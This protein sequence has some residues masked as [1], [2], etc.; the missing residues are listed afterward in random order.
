MMP[1]R[2]LSTVIGVALAL[3][4][5]PLVQVIPAKADLTFDQ[6]MVELI[7]QD[8][9]ANGLRPVAADPTLSAQAEDAPYS[10]CG[11][12]VNGRAMDMGQRNYFSHSILGCGG[13]GIFDILNSTGLVYSGAGENIAWVNAVTDPLVAAAN[14]ENQLMSDL[15]H[16]GNIL[17]PNFTR[18]G[19][20]SWHTNA[21][22]TWS[23]SGTAL[24]RVY[25]G[26]QIFS[27]GEVTPAPPPPPAPPAQ[28]AGTGFHPLTPSRILD[29]RVGKGAPTAP[30]GAGATLNVQVTGRG[31]VP[32]TG[33]SAV[34]LNVTVT[35]PTAVSYLTVFP[36][37]EAVPPSSNLDF[38]PGQTVPN[39]V[40]AKLGTNGQ[41]SIFN[42]YGTAQVIADVA[43]WYD[44]GTDPN[45]SRYHP[46]SPSRILDTRTANGAPAAAIGAGAPLTLQVTGRG[47]V[48]S[49]GVS[50][51]V[52]N[53]TVAQPTASSNLSVYPT[54]EAAPVASNLNFGPGQTIS[55]LV[56]AKVG[57]N[58]QVSLINST[59][60]THVVADVAGWYDAGSG[61]AGAWFHPL[62]P[63]RVLDTRTGNGAATGPLGTRAM[64]LQAAGRGG[65]PSTGVSAV[66]LNVTVTGPSAASY[67]T[68]FPTGE[69]VPAAS[70][71]NF[72]PGQTVPNLV[73]AKLG[74]NGNVSLYNVAGTTH[75]IADV[76]GWFDLAAAA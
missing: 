15:G 43:G 36:A 5:S 63:S 59:G 45:G 73:V 58:G 18:V 74:A 72:T 28:P 61:S 27:S 13:R 30:I 25:I 38:A 76:A 62:S 52:L 17:N 48:P 55:N 14:L 23:G 8:R 75:V 46:V 68:V 35:G 22:Q 54:G 65:V 6:R 71:L 40:V 53:V 49:T 67:L 64:N 33:A 50:A 29:T 21:G 26:V 20:G 66:V 19:V 42:P 56:M 60:S 44:T 2:R 31:G 3:L 34:V 32:S 37:G 16:R 7:N 24:T 69:A 1:K 57:S 9:A 39:L 51:V 47:G 41:V 10:G 70:N 12:T 4:L 11:F